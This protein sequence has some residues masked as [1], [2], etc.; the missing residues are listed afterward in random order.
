MT[1]RRSGLLARS[2]ARA[3]AGTTTLVHTGGKMVTERVPDMARGVVTPRKV[4][5]DIVVDMARVVA[6][7]PEKAEMTS[8][9]QTGIVVAMESA[10]AQ[11]SAAATLREAGMVSV[12]GMAKEIKCAAAMA[13][14]T[15]M[16]R[17]VA[18]AAAMASAAAMG[19]A[20]ATASAAAMTTTRPALVSGDGRGTY[21]AW[22]HVRR[23]TRG[24]RTARRH[25]TTMT[26]AGSHNLWRHA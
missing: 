17:E 21:G 11:K 18:I 10:A 6:T 25:S 9:A 4:D 3:E 5:M 23:R 22:R 2:S 24:P 7:T 19:S 20:A 12:T 16:A 8:V 15:S 1:M 14:A 13:T 26:S